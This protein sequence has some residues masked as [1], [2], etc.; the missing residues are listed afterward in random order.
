MSIYMLSY[1]I[2]RF[3][4]E[5][6]RADDRGSTIVN[7]LTP[8]QLTAVIMILGSILVFVYTNIVSKRKSFAGETDE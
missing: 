5:N 7:F 3:I 2:W 1:G 4:I 6:F 8:S